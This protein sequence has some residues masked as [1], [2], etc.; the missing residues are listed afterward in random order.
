MPILPTQLQF[1]QYTPCTSSDK[2]Y[3]TYRLRREI[4]SPEREEAEYLDIERGVAAD[5]VKDEN[6]AVPKRG[7]RGPDL[8]GSEA[9]E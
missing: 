6:V 1:A 8:E 3:A 9:E 7:E 4:G 2:R 5:C